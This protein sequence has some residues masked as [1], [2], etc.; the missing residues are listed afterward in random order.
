MEGERFDP[1]RTLGVPIGAGPDEVRRAWRKQVRRKHPDV[2]RGDATAHEEFIRLRQAYETLMDDELRARLERQVLTVE[3]EPLL[4]I[5]DWEATLLDAYELLDR[6]YLDEA[7]AIYLELS[8][9]HAGDPR[10][11]ELLD[12]IHR[13]EG[14]PAARPE[15]RRT[16]V[17]APAEARRPPT[18]GT[19]GWESYRDLWL[20]EPTPVRWWLAALGLALTAGLVAAVRVADTAP[21]LAGLSALELAIAAVAGFAAAA[22]AAAGGLLKSFDFELGGSVADRAGAVPLC[23]YLAV[24]GLISPGLA[25]AFYLVF[26]ALQMPLSWRVLG[27]FAGMLTIAA[28]MG[29]ARNGRP[30]SLLLVG[31]NVIFVSGL[32]GWA[33]GSAFRPG[34]WWE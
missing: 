24:A 11:L 1:W 7:R 21:V 32:V 23:L 25:L 33:V 27:F 9:T 16:G 26:V 8:R 34:Y 3:D 5:E 10:L 14:R 29:W 6:G 31:A 13:V 19:Y 12:A 15:R 18:P 28:A 22:C 2:R 4:I 17:A 30:D 20:P